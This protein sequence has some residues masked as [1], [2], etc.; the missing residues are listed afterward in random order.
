MT[1]DLRIRPADPQDPA[2]TAGIF[3]RAVRDGTR[4]AYDERQ[5][6]AWAPGIPDA[7][8][9]TDRLRDQT[10]FVAET[11]GDIVG[12]VALRPAGHVDLIFVA[13]EWHR[14]GIGRHLLDELE[15]HAR[16]QGLLLLSADVSLSAKRLFLGHGWRVLKAQ[17]VTTNGADLTNFRMEKA[18]DAG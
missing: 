15:R 2:K 6:A 3:F 5:R 12:F 4:D 11:A 1:P 7:T 16:A 14:L 9:W 8:A 18:L 17:S 13:P 10:V